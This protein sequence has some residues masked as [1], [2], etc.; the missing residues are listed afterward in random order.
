MSSRPL[1]EWSKDLT[2]IAS[3]LFTKVLPPLLE[4]AD[5]FEQVMLREQLDIFQQMTTRA[6]LLPSDLE[7]LLVLAEALGA[8]STF[9][10]LLARNQAER[11]KP[12]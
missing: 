7:R 10:S 3:S 5:T 4:Q 2:Q 11:L 6:L 9:S 12:A 1:D 8:V